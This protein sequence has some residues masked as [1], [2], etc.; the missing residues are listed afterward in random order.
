MED[1]YSKYSASVL[2]DTQRYSDLEGETDIGNG[3]GVS[4]GIDPRYKIEIGAVAS[5]QGPKT[6]I[7]AVASLQ[8][9]KTEIGWDAP[10][11]SPESPIELGAIASMD[12]QSVEIGYVEPWYRHEIGASGGNLEPMYRSEI[13][14]SGGNLAPMYRSE[15]G[16]S[17]GNLEPMYRAEIGAEAVRAVVEKARDNR[18]PTPAMRAV[19]ADSAPREDDASYWLEDVTIGAAMAAGG[20]D[21]F[22]LTTQLMQRFGADQ[23]GTPKYVRVDTEKSYSA[24]RA[25]QS[26]ELSELKDK[27]SEL[28]SRLEEHISD[29]EA[30]LQPVDE[31][32]EEVDV[33]GAEAAEAEA[34]KRVELWLSPD[35]EGCIHAWREGDFVCASI[36]LPGSDG[37]IRI[38]TSMVPIVKCVDEMAR[39][40]AEAK[41]PSATVLGVLP[42]M[43]CVLGAATLVKEMV[44]AAPSILSQPEADTGEPFVVRIE[45][46]ANPAIATFMALLQECHAGNQ[47]ACAEWKALSDA[48]R[49]GG[50]APVAQAM[51]E[52]AELLKKKA[53]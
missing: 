18:Q 13:G 11:W 34:S 33:M 51:T 41:V 7:G 6:E 22:P 37:E 31:M 43:G 29:P 36:H 14:A 17:G 38:C 10:A 12:G 27:L 26:P 50:A 39:H 53:A 25:G 9:T 42:A 52:A 8:G 16:A 44:A 15:I 4:M 23:Q 48:A 24:F 47:Q 40:A 45:P 2:E 20:T 35:K 19:P 1:Q 28:E 46:K 32:I 21:M 49:S 30:H 5:L 3:P